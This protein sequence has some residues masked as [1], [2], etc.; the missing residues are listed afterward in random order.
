MTV[1]SFFSHQS[2][3]PMLLQHLHSSHLGPM[4]LTIGHQAHHIV[5]LVLHPWLLS[6]LGLLEQQVRVSPEVNLLWFYCII[7]FLKNKAA[8]F[9]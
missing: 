9:I 3:L 7:Y 1:Y 8:M 4:R 5:S 6:H 2:E